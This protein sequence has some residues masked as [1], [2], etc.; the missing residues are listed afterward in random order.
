MMIGKFMGVYQ[1]NIMHMFGD[2]QRP[3]PISDKA[4]YHKSLVKKNNNWVPLL[5]IDIIMC[6]LVTRSPH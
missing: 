5:Y 2:D 3:I 4:S 1:V 6:I